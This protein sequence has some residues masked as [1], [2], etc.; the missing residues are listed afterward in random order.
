MNS[1]G[2]RGFVRLHSESAFSGDAADRDTWQR[3]RN[4]DDAWNQ[5]ADDACC[6]GQLD[7]R[8]RIQLV[9]YSVRRF[10]HRGFVGSHPPRVESSEAGRYPSISL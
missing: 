2:A 5:M 9:A 4:C 1:G 7:A 6:S 3:F 8:D 10:G